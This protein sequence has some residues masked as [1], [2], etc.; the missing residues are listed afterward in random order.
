MPSDFTTDAEA[1]RWNY[2]P[3]E[4]VALNPL[5]AWPPK[6]RAVVRW[7][8]AYWMALTASTLTV[9]F[10]V[11]VFFAIL[12]PLETMKEWNRDWVLRVYLANLVPHC[13]CA[14]LLHYWLYMRE[15][16]GSAFKFDARAQAVDNGT[17]SF[18]D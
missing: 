4:P 17:F 15:G 8:R 13:V 11:F 7:C 14:G 1:G 9:A 10:A 18:R 12:P 5:F 2:R 3:P 16:P 6:P